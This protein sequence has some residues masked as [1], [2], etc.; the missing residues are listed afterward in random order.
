MYIFSESEPVKEGIAGARI[1]GQRE[2]D[3]LA[4][5]RPGNTPTLGSITMNMEIIQEMNSLY[6]LYRQL[7]LS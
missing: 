5:V 4:D 6:C 3:G 1:G 2:D 7:Y